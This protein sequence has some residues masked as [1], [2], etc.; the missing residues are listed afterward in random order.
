MKVEIEVPDEI[1]EI[2]EYEAKRRAV[3]PESIIKLVL[4]E[5]AM[6]VSYIYQIDKEKDR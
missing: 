1:M 6:K 3:A 5:H 2:I 4:S